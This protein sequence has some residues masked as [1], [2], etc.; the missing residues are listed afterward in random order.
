MTVFTDQAQKLS[1]CQ[2]QLT[3]R[4][5]HAKTHNTFKRGDTKPD[6][7]LRH[8]SRQGDV[9]EMTNVR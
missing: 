5:R 9:K 7:I 6:S 3:E 1:S 4:N 2:K 8:D